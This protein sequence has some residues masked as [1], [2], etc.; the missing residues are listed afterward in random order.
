MEK[1][2]S[3]QRWIENVRTVSRCDNDDALGT[4]EAVHFDEHLVERLLTF[5]VTAT[6]TRTTVPT[7]CVKLIDEDDARGLFLGLIDQAY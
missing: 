6:K 7:D 1:T 3:Q 4:L 2:R 5:I